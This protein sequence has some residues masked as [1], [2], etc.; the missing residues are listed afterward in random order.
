MEETTETWV[1]IDLFCDGLGDAG[2]CVR[3]PSDDLGTISDVAPTAEVARKAVLNA[4]VK[5]RWSFDGN[6]QRWL[7]PECVAVRDAAR[8]LTSAFGYVH[9]TGSIAP[10]DACPSGPATYPSGAASMSEITT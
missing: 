3:D 1:R 4:V 7:C 10:T 9:Q 8:D 5:S 2:V 6:M